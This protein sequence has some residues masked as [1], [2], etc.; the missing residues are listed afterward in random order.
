MQQ[1][2]LIL[3][4]VAVSRDYKNSNNANAPCSDATDDDE[5]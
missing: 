4:S 3:S 1:R 2:V 5:K